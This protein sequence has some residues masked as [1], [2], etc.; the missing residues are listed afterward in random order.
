[1]HQQAATKTPCRGVGLRRIPSASKSEP[2]LTST[3]SCTAFENDETPKS[4]GS[5]LKTMGRKSMPPMRCLSNID[6]PSGK[7]SSIGSQLESPDNP[8]VTSKRPH[9]LIET[10]DASTP[11][12]P[13]LS[14][15]II[16]PTV[17]DLQSL[18]KRIAL[19]EKRINELRRAEII[20]RKHSPEKL[21]EEIQQWLHGC[22]E[23]LQELLD[24][25]NAK[26]HDAEMGKLLLEL[27]IP[28]ELVQFNNDSQEFETETK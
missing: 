28:H 24:A 9:S 19:K 7:A 5:L 22:Q 21:K 15:T 8:H 3:L 12:K 6:I 11:K 10:S 20:C 13:K 1:M 4:H 14:P 25:V 27:G 18:R 16:A 2:I 26:G 17:D 23:A